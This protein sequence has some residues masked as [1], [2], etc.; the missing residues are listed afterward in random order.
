MVE[1]LPGEVTPTA[2]FFF[3]KRQERSAKRPPEV[4]EDMPASPF[5][6]FES[7]FKAFERTFTSFERT[8]RAFEPSVCALLGCSLPALPMLLRH[9]PMAGG[10]RRRGAYHHQEGRVRQREGRV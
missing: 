6:A 3:V 1:K 2:A 9:W 4:R 7:S 10:G 5:Q 8:F